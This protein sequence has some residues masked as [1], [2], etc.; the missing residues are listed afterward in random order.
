LKLEIKAALLIREFELRS[1]PKALRKRW[2]WSSKEICFLKRSHADLD[3][4]EFFFMDREP[5]SFHATYLG[6]ANGK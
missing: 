3:F 5:A 4:Q 2:D 6:V 1:S